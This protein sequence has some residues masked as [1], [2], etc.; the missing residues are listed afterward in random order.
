MCIILLKWDVRI[1]LIQCFLCIS[2]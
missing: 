1:L 2:C